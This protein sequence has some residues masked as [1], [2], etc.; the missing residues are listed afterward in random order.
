MHTLFKIVSG[1]MLWITFILFIGG[2]LFK[3]WQLYSLA[4]RKENFIF[5]YFSLKYGLRSLAHWLTPFATVNMRN[6]PVMTIVTFAFHICLL[7]LPVF[8]L[9]HIVLWDEAWGV[10][11][12]ALP[13]GLADIMTLVVLAA[14]IFFLI[15]RLTRPEVRYVTSASDFVLLAIVAAPFATGF[16]CYHQW[17]G[18]DYALIAHML[19]GEIMLVAI[20]FTRLSHMLVGLFT[21][22]YMGSEFGGVRHAKDW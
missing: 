7:L 9:S 3:L 19:T 14:C 6:H 20:P 2:C 5:S 12:W 4:R 10:E 11:W 21:R 17:P 22:G 16:Y 18:Y 15:R 1:P 8:V 13:D